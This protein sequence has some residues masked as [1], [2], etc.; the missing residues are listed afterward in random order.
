MSV[1]QGAIAAPIPTLRLVAAPVAKGI[2]MTVTLAA[3]TAET[4]RTPDTLAAAKH[5]AGQHGFNPRAQKPGS[6][7]VYPVNDKGESTQAVALGQEPI[8]EW[9]GDFEFSTGIG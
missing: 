5:I 9:R 2:Y 6:P 4:L 8:H 7:N 1:P 3:Q